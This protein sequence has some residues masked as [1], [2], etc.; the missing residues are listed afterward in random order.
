[1]GSCSF[2][3]EEVVFVCSRK[4]REDLFVPVFAMTAIVGYSLII[5][6]DFL[7]MKGVFD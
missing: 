6:F 3:N 4:R 5:A 2:F 1:M 7:R